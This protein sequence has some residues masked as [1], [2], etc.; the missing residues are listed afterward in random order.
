MRS[1]CCQSKKWQGRDGDPEVSL[2]LPF[3]ILGIGNCLLGDDGVGVHAARAL[4]IHPPPRT[5]VVDAGTDFLGALPFLEQCQ[6][7][8]VIDAMDANGPPGAIYHCRSEDLEA[9]GRAYSLHDRGLL[10]VL[11]FIEIHRRPPIQVLGVQPAHIEFGL[12]L[13][14][15]VAAALP[16]LMAASHR[17]IALKIW[18]EKA[19]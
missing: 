1:P 19:C 8:L 9:G 17:I 13:S 16:Y 5:Q 6:R 12:N 15:P 11:E 10:S 3:L 2:P 18:R 7:A 14:R 4:Q